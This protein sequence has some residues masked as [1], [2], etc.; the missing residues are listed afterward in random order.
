MRE[1]LCI[2]IPRRWVRVFNQ[3]QIDCLFRLITKNRSIARA[4]NAGGWINIKIQSYQYRKSH[5]GDKTILRPSYLHNGI[6]YTSKMTSLYWTRALDAFPCH[7]VIMCGTE[8]DARLIKGRTHYNDV[9]MDATA[10]QIT[11]L[12]IV[13]WTIY[14][15]SDQRKH[16]RSASLAF[17]S[18][19]NSP[20]KGAVTRKMFSFDDVIMR[21]LD[22][23][24]V[25][26]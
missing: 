8:N 19:V 3:G 7:R 17:V 25:L 10:S 24:I 20:H 16:Q 5:C 14:S 11:S 15:G 26:F 12:T 18:P 4:S 9:I 2:R 21:R 22:G 23:N 6:S 1:I 13:Y